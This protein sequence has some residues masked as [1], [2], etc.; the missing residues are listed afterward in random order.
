LAEIC[1]HIDHS[2]QQMPAEINPCR[3]VKAAQMGDR[4]PDRLNFLKPSRLLG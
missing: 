1:D 2:K 4:W 3:Q